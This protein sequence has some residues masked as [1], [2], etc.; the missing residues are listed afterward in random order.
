MQ[1]SSQLWP[2]PTTLLVR[3]FLHGANGL[4]LASCMVINYEEIFQSGKE[5]T[6]LNVFSQS[7]GSRRRRDAQTGGRG[8]SESI[9]CKVFKGRSRLRSAKR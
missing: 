1:L 3:R 8:A 4:L 5:G 7:Q 9:R 2:A 6:I